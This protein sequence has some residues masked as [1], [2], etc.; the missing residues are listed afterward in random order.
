MANLASLPF[1]TCVVIEPLREH[2]PMRRIGSARE[3][4][5]VLLYQWPPI[6]KKQ[7]HGEATLACYFALNGEGTVEAAHAAFIAAAKDAGLFLWE[8]PMNSNGDPR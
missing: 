4:A 5:E 3:A 6:A 2:G 7:R 8:A 1:P